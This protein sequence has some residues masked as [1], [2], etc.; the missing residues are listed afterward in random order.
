MKFAFVLP[1]VAAADVPLTMSWEEWKN[2]FGM[3]FNS[4]L[5]DDTRKAVFEANVATIEAENAKGNTYT[6]G[7]N[8][9]AH[10]TEDEFVAQY[11][12]GDGSAVGPDDAH[13]GV[14]EIGERAESVDWTTQAGVVNPV[15]DQGQCGS[16]WAFSAVGTVESAYALAAGKL[17]SY[18]EQQVVDCDTSRSQGCEG[19][20]NQYA[21]TYIGQKGSAGES[22]YPY[23]GKDGTCRDSTVSKKLAAGTVTG[24]KS[25][26]ASNEGLQSA[27][28]TQPVSVT[29]KAGLNWQLYRSGVLSKDC[30]GILSRPN[31]A[32]IAVGY[33]ADTFKIRNSWGKSWGEAGHVRVSNADADPMCLWK[34][35]PFI[36]TLS[37]DVTV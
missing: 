4:G 29:V 20:F 7:V 11:T 23:T 10:L 17:D 30:G 15:K 19:G 28:N 13:M 12:G 37:A 22:A 26:T 14:L 21:M 35:T 36:P 32:V 5:E 9:F 27:L 8:Q 16:C 1:F 18:S 6:L 3:V 33:D 24:Y 2:E 25:V 31:H 34:T